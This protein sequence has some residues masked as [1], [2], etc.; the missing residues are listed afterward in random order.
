[1]SRSLLFVTLCTLSALTLADPPAR[2]H[3]RA[4]DARSSGQYVS[5]QTILYDAEVREPGRIIE[6]ELDEEDDEYEIEILRSDGIV[7]ELEYDA[8]TGELLDRDIED[9]D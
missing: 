7:V 3:E 6:V 5:L 1:M 9:D 8:R 4:R 2:D